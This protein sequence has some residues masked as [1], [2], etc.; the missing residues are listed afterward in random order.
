MQ[1]T[2]VTPLAKTQILRSCLPLSQR[3]RFS[4]LLVLA[5]QRQMLT[6]EDCGRLEVHMMEDRTKIARDAAARE[7]EEKRQP[8]CVPGKERGV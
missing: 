7:H 8:L 5:L 1:F 2:R 3:V 6:K 4:I